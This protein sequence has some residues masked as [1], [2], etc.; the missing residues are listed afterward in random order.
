MYGAIIGDLAGS[1]YEFDQTKGIKNIKMNKVIEDNA[2]FSDDTIE[3]MAVLDALLKDDYTYEQAL[4]D[5]YNRFKEY[6]SN[7]KP[8]FKNPFSPGFIKWAKGDNLGTSK[9]NGALM[10]I[11]PIPMIIDDELEMYLNTDL[12]TKTSHDSK[13]ALDAASTVASIIYKARQGWS[14]YDIAEWQGLELEYIPFTKFNTTCEE[15]LPNCLNALFEATSFEDAIERTLYMGGDTDTNCC[16]VGSMAEP[17]Y[18]IPNN[19]IEEA[20]K[21]IPEDFQKLLKKGYKIV[22][23]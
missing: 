5:Y 23:K 22:N 15:T 10:R 21:K 14:K 8:Y 7:F 4:I 2:F 20:N 17:L 1:I 19:L 13:E 11:S 6:K 9:G 3:T 18:G 16:I 12:C